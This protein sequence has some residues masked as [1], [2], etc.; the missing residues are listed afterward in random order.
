MIIEIGTRDVLKFIAI[1]A[2]AIM[3]GCPI[4]FW[5]FTLYYG[6]EQDFRNWRRRR[7]KCSKPER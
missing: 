3:I 4:G 1:M 2:I 7:R 6:W 5:L